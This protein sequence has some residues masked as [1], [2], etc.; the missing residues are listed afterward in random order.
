MPTPAGRSAPLAE[1]QHP[2]CPVPPPY[3]A[4]PE[5]HVPP[6]HLLPEQLLP[7]HLLPEH[8]VPPQPSSPTRGPSP[9]CSFVH[10]VT[11]PV[12]VTIPQVRAR[13]RAALDEWRVSREVADVLLLAVSELVGNVVRHAAD[14]WMRVGV[15]RGGGWLRLEVADQGAGLPRLPSPQAEADLDSEGGRGLLI[16]QLLAAEFGGELSVVAG[17]SGKSVRM[18]VPAA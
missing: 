14:G 1:P 13:V 15:N 16:V 3:S 10:W 8:R 4:P 6:E 17:E 18:R 5:H 9:A 11:D 2:G 12:A 7:E